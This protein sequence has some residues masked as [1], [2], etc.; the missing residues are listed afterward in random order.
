MHKI[1]SQKDVDEYKHTQLSMGVECHGNNN[2]TKIDS[3]VF[4]ENLYT[5]IFT[6]IALRNERT[7]SKFAKLSSIILQKCMLTNIEF[8][9]GMKNLLSV[10]ILENL[11]YDLSPLS[12]CIN[13]E[14]LRCDQNVISNI[15]VCKNFTKMKELKS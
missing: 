10:H 5:L 7:I 12:E 2:F 9:R 15:D 14:V 3:S 4:S 6:N 8:L 11:I 13:I 1:R